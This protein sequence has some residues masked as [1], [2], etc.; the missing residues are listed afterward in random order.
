MMTEEPEGELRIRARNIL[1]A[2]VLGRGEVADIVVA[3]RQIE[4]SPVAGDEPRGEKNVGRHTVVIVAF[5]G[6][7]D[8]AAGAVADPRKHRA[9]ERARIGQPSLGSGAH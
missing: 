4:R 9:L 6:A 1:R 7:V 2:S 8:R 5:T 3:E